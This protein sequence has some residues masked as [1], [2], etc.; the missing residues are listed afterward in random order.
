MMLASLRERIFTSIE[1]FAVLVSTK[2][3][4]ALAI[5]LASL[6]LAAWMF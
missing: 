6:V 3:K 1:W 2:P 5:W 4:A